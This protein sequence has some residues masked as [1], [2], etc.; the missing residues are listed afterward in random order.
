[1]TIL[2]PGLFSAQPGERITVDVVKS[3]APY[4]VKP[5]D[6]IGGTWSPRPPDAGGLNAQGGFAMPSNDVNFSLLFNFIP[7][8]APDSEGDFY[9]VTLTGSNGGAF[10]QMIFGPGFTTRTYRF[11]VQP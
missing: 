2:R 6:L 11:Q 10:P 9:M 8:A 3:F 5:S 4:S 1:M 7:G